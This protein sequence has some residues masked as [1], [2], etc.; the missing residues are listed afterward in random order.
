MRVLLLAVAAMACLPP[1]TASTQT[2]DELV[3]RHV[4]ARG[5]Y[6]K[7]KAIQTIKITRVVATPFG[8]VRAINYRKRPH[9]L[10]IEQGPADPGAPL[11]PRGVNAEGAW[12]TIQGRIVLR[13]EALAAETRELDTDFDGLLVD[14]KQKGHTVTLEGKE[15]LPAGEAYKLTVRLR[16]GA[17]RTIYLDAR[18][19]LER[20]QIGILNLPGGRQFNI[21]Q[22]FDNYREVN[23][24]KFPFDIN[25]DRTG[26]EPAQSYVIYTDKIEVNV[27]MDDALFATP[28]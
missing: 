9:L 22:D 17:V 16:S 7:I 24:V 26:K 12:D 19:Y 8:N 6:D 14:W 2:V 1:S 20:R 11:I 4:E 25:E 27:P 23:G 21:V 15:Q 13:P 18:T 5:G 28:K 10:R 3:A